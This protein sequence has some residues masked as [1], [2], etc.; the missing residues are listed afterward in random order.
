VKTLLSFFGQILFAVL[1]VLGVGLLLFYMDLTDAPGI[2]QAVIDRVQAEFSQTT[3][4]LED[5]Y[6]QDQYLQDPG[7]EEVDLPDFNLPDLT[8]P[9]QADIQITVAGGGQSEITNL[10]PTEPLPVVTM[11]A[12]APTLAPTA[13]PVP[14]LDPVVY[15]TEAT[16]RLKR[17]VAA[18]ERWLATNDQ[19]MRDNNLLQ[20]AAWRSQVKDNLAE[21][22]REGHSLAN[23]GKPPDVY[24][25][26]D[27]WL[28]R[29]GLESERLQAYYLQALET[30][31]ASDFTSAGDSF[32]RI[33]KYLA[34]AAQA[35][36]VAG[37]TFE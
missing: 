22:V 17:Y 27:G 15:Q 12:V 16:I 37:W 33:K 28:V 29:A 36:L 1:T 8:N 19:L 2:L 34:Q 25:D 14:P 31:S 13:T 24:A 7:F 26:I 5:K 11:R 32:T 23:I 21:I 3:T 4:Y 10:V 9:G 18:L 20:D 35:M 30:G 6:L